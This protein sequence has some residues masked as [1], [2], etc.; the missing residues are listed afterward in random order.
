VDAKTRT[1]VL[2]IIAGLESRL[3]DETYPR[4]AAA[5]YALYALQHLTGTYRYGTTEPA[6]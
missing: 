2:D 5:E 4:Q 6:H 1:A 3:A